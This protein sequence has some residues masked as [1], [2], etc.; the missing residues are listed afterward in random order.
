MTS[1][2]SRVLGT[3]IILDLYGC[4][5]ELMMHVEDVQLLMREAAKRAHFTVVTEEYHQFAPCGVSGATIIQ[6][7]HLTWHSWPEHGYASL[8]IYYCGENLFVD[9]GI[10]YL[11][12]MLKPQ[13]V[14]RVHIPRGIPEKY[15]AYKS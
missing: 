9:D 2:M 5:S 7:S 12:E 1:E 10:N 3:H 4:V 15:L 11:I 14:E 6:E 8:D 13:H